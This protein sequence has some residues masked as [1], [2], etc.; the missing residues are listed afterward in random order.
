MWLLCGCG[1]KNRMFCELQAR[2][3]GEFRI[4]F[5]VPSHILSHSLLFSHSHTFVIVIPY[6]I[7][8]VIVRLICAQQHFYGLMEYHLHFNDYLWANKLRTTAK[9]YWCIISRELK[10]I[11]TYVAQ[12]FVHRAWDFFPRRHS[13]VH[14]LCVQFFFCSF[15]RLAH[16]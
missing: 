13:S 6:F 15:V 10:G 11:E 8:L 4:F 1:T 14:N 16:L 7:R 5:F 3:C 9:N 12:I 2:V